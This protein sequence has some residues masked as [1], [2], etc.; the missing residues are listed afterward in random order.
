MAS[1]SI[2]PSVSEMVELCVNGLG[3]PIFFP[4]HANGFASASSLHLSIKLFLQD[5]KIWVEC[6]IY[7]SAT[8]LLSSTMR[9]NSRVAEHESSMWELCASK[10]KVYKLLDFCTN[11][12][13]EICTPPHSST[14]TL[15]TFLVVKVKIEPGIHNFI[16]LS[17]SSDGDEPPVST[18]IHKP[19]SS[20]L[21]S[22]FVIPP[23]LCHFPPSPAKPSI[24]ILQCLHIL[25][26]MPGRKNI[27]KKLDYDTLQIEEENFLRARFDGNRTFVL[28]PIGVLSSH[29]PNP[30]TT[31]T[32]AMT[33]IFGPR[34][35]PPISTMT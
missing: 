16:H 25:A 34:P 19:S 1:S 33:A 12:S 20:S 3:I 14:S 30:W 10:Y 15:N 6:E 35:K 29:R 4:V 31:W 2:V 11:V 24:F 28:P 21:H 23:L 27:L 18:P 17:D 9:E 22:T 13:T 26:S 32:K 7:D 8:F 5:N